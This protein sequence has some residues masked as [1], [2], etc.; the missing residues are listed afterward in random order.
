MDWY[1]RTEGP[2]D[3]S[4]VAQVRGLLTGTGTESRTERTFL[5][6]CLLV[7]LLVATMSLWLPTMANA[8]PLPPGVYTAAIPGG[9][10]VL[11]IHRDGLVEVSAPPSTD[12]ELAY[13]DRGRVLDA[14]IAAG[15]T[16]A[17]EPLAESDPEAA[18]AGTTDVSD[19]PTTPVTVTDDAAP[20][21]DS[22][23]T[24]A[25]QPGN[26]PDSPP[27]LPPATPPGQVDEDAPGRS[28]LEH[29]RE[30]APGQNKDGDPGR[31]DDLDDVP[32]APPGRSG[33][34]P[35][36]AGDAPAQDD[37]PSADDGAG[38]GGTD[39]ADE[40]DE[41]APTDRSSTPPGRSVRGEDS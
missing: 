41:T 22:A 1:E 2:V 30:T 18:T 21:E 28:G 25:E 24:G 36:R 9:T 12:V 10:V 34:A 35:A 29:G 13:D 3:A 8:E 4:G 33:D 32:T 6:S 40:A 5:L 27:G 16:V 20:T 19:S 14:F 38:D 37:E 26:A 15:R 17:W 7:A 11:E 31:D 23:P 39:T